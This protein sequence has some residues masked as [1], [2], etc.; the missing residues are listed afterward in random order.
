MNIE[1]KSFIYKL[2]LENQ[3][4]SS[5]VAKKFEISRSFISNVISGKVLCPEYLVKYF[6]DLCKSYED[7]EKKIE[8]LFNEN[9]IKIRGNQNYIIFKNCKELS[10]KKI[11]LLSIIRENYKILDDNK[12][13]KIIQEIKNAKL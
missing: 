13:D 6:K 1:L 4:K 5:D 10:E 8:K 7:E 2:F 3:I 11:E 9:N 12:L